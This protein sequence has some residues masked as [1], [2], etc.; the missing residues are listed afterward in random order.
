MGIK[1][2]PGNAQNPMKIAFFTYPAAFQNVGGGEVSL[3]KLKEYLEKEGVQADLFD[4]W[5][6]KIEEYNFIH[7]F[8]SVKDCL[9]LVRVANAR[10]VKVA[11]SPLLWSD[12]RRAIYTDGPFSMKADLLIRHLV[13][14]LYP[15]FPSARRELLMRSDLIFP[16]SEIEKEHVARFFAIP[17]QKMKVLYNGVDIEFASARPDAFRERYG[18]EPFILG[19]GRIEPRKNQWNLIKAVKA[20]KGKKLVLIGSPVT[21]YE[22]YY[23][24]CR[25]EGE[26]FTTFLSTIKHEDPVLRSAYAA[27]ELFVL[28]GWF[29]TPGLVALEAALAGANVVATSGGSTKDYF[30]DHVEYLNPA[31]PDDMKEKILKSMGKQN[32]NLKNHVLDH[33]TWDKIAKSAISFYQEVLAH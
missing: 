26:G 2:Q 16:N 22:E 7:V 3:L 14:A 9:G 31:S 29:E 17:L 25:K 33:F 19:V 13:K 5:R 8:G 18:D 11:I 20:I 21:G 32:S 4:T 30:K 12:M 1:I 28:Q 15:A 23:Q 10:K 24:S 6:S 27:C